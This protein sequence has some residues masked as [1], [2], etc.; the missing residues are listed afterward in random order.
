VDSHIYDGMEISP[1][2]D[3]LLAKVITQAEDRQQARVRMIGALRRFE[4][5]G[6]ATTRDL[7]LEILEHPAFI[8]GRVTTRFL[9]EQLARA[10]RS[11]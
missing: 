7:C 10:E 6:P 8:A 2:Y 9:E 3:S 1:Y 4:L 5:E 11:A